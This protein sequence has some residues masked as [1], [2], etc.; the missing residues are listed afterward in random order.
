MTLLSVAVLG[1]SVVVAWLLWLEHREELS[2]S[3]RTRNNEH[4]STEDTPGR[5]C[6]LGSL[7]EDNEVRFKYELH[8]VAA[9]D[10]W[11]GDPLL[12]NI[13]N[14]P[15]RTDWHRGAA[16]DFLKPELDWSKNGD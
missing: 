14:I 4:F 7:D 15:W 5:V 11:S 12:P 13:L 3:A 16:L 8:G 2:A 10:T 9:F 6:S 1:T